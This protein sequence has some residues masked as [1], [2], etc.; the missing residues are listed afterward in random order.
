MR[1]KKTTNMILCAAI[2]GLTMAVAASQA[3]AAFIN[4]TALFLE[5][6]EHLATGDLAV[7][8]DAWTRVGSPGT[9]QVVTGNIGGV[10]DKVLKI[11]PGASTYDA[12]IAFGAPW[13]DPYVALLEP[14]PGTQ[15]RMSFDISF[16][17]GPTGTECFFAVGQAEGSL[18]YAN[19]V[20]TGAVLNLDQG[21]GTRVPLIPAIVAN[22][23]YHLDVDIDMDDRTVVGTATDGTDT[24]TASVNLRNPGQTY[25]PNKALIENMTLTA[26]GITSSYLLDNIN[27]APVPEPGTATLLS[28]VLLSLAF[29]GWRRRK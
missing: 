3:S 28:L 29:Y 25:D 22:T 20:S 12:R 19:L 27:C 6:W 7:N 8:T 17:T 18:A 5:D 4:T 21:D 13:S 1:E 15:W 9:V 2:L 16:L 11:G 23:P 14:G 24:W 10:G 26:N